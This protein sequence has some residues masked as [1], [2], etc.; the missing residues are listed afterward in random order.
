M[1]RNFKSGLK[2]YLNTNRFT[3]ETSRV[4]FVRKSLQDLSKRHNIERKN[5][6]TFLER[7]S[8]K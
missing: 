8:A 7:T 4:A 1:R 5:L 3:S 6:R 2:W